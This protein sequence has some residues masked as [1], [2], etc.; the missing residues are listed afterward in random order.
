MFLT[1]NKQLLKDFILILYVSLINSLMINTRMMITNVL[2]LSFL[3]FSV[4][5]RNIIK[6]S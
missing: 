4:K 3:T 1:S 6:V 2:H 5:G